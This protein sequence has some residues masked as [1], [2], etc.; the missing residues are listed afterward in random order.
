MNGRSKLLIDNFTR[1]I[2][3][4][5]IFFCK[6]KNNIP[7]DKTEIYGVGFRKGY[8]IGRQKGIDDAE[9]YQE[10]L[11]EDDDFVNGLIQKHKSHK[12]CDVTDP[13]K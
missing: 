2:K 8:A 7:Y 9:I 6:P 13:V 3:T 4:I 1:F 12:F 10:T 5:S 11:C